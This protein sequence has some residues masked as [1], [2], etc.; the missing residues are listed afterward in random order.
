[1]MNIKL[2]ARQASELA[3]VINEYVEMCDND[4]D[5][6]MRL[7]DITLPD[8]KGNDYTAD[9]AIKIEVQPVMKKVL[10]NILSEVD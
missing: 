2:T 5:P 1:M 7:F 10:V 6:I 4:G 9:E 3:G 8:V